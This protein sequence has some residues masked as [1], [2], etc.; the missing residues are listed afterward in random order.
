MSEENFK[1]RRKKLGLTQEA[2]G[3]KIGKSIRTIQNWESGGQEIPSYAWTLLD[4]L[5]EKSD[6]DEIMGVPENDYMMVE[7]QDLEVAAGRIGMGGGD[8]SFLPETKKRLLPKEYAKGYYLVVRIHGHSMDDG[9][10][11]SISEGEELLI[12]EFQDSLLNLPIRSKLF[13]IVTNEG[14]VVKQIKKIDTENKVLV[15]HSFNPTWDDY[16]V[17]FDEVLQIFTVEKK[18]K[19]NIIF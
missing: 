14:S 3:K 5:E 1:Q 19:A 8:I 18:V 6:N 4:R 13:V 2:L 15:L 10:K 17:N 11:R 7:F 16:T 12:R 9:T